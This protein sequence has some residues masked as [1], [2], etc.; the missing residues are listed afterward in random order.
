MKTIEERI[1]YL[2]DL[3]KPL[4]ITSL[5]TA[6]IGLIFINLQD[7][8]SP[9]TWTWKGAVGISFA[10]VAAITIIIIVIVRKRKTR[11]QDIEMEKR[12][13][14]EITEQKKPTWQEPDEKCPGLARQR[15]DDLMKELA[16]NLTVLKAQK[17]CASWLLVENNGKADQNQEYYKIQRQAIFTAGRISKVR[18]CLEDIPSRIKKEKEYAL[19]TIENLQER[20]KTMKHL[21]HEL[22]LAE[23][24]IFVSLEKQWRSTLESLEEQLATWK[25][26]IKS[27]DKPDLPRYFL[28]EYH[29]GLE[30]KLKGIEG[31]INMFRENATLFHYDLPAASLRLNEA[32]ER[33]HALIAYEPAF[34]E[35]K[36]RSEELVK[37]L[38]QAQG[39]IDTS[40]RAI[41]L[42]LHEENKKNLTL[43]LE[44]IRKAEKFL[45][46][47]ESGHGIIITPENVIN[48]GSIVEESKKHSI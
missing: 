24:T 46:E 32:K 11:L 18:S 41:G 38:D 40:L 27:A 9:L 14:K 12:W 2:R 6:T 7:A 35:P 4:I 3:E 33:L 29:K 17:D 30:E 26:G 42:G 8:L 25:E 13:W 31:P 22:L 48:V 28:D 37:D 10:G 19:E 43:T 45:E 39:R 21:V 47:M 5:I 23:Y 44:A 34:V 15:Y 20:V 1:I 16:D 36:K